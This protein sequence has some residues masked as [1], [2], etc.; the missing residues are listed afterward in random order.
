ML[1]I[2]CKIA[3]NT[4]SILQRRALE[5]RRLRVAWDNRLAGQDKAGTGVYAA[6]LLEQF[7]NKSDLHMDILKGWG[8]SRRGGLVTAGSR[9]AGNLFWTHAALP[10][11]LWRLGSQVL[12]SPAFV[13]P[14]P[15][16]CPVVTTIHDI[17]YLL[18]PSHFSKWWTAYLNLVMPSVV[19]SAAAIICPSENSKRDI[20]KAYGV[21]VD[22]IRV[23]PQ[24]VDHERFHPSARL[25]H[26]WAQ[27]LGI[28]NGYVLHIGTFSYRKNI[29]TLL[30]A[31]AELRAR[32]MWE[33]RQ[34]LLAGSQ[35]LSLKGGHEIIGTIRDLDLKDTVVL[36][37]YMPEEHVPGLYAH[38]SMLVMPSIYEGFGFP[39]L[40]AMATG[41]PVICSD[42]SSLPEVAGDAAVFFPPHDQHAL[43][44]AIETLLRTPSIREQLRRKGIERAS[45]FTWQRTAE[46]TIA[47]YR[48]VAKS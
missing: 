36:T 45:Q 8:P 18:Y 3:I 15:C 7:A 20:I 35:H 41:T 2:I 33:N 39:V 22:K 16:P 12:H 32:G 11:L 46:R 38:A 4:A 47:V 34:L 25:Q 13:T 17:S 42:E 9:A 30:R 29:P 43:A 14:I 6:R 28:R 37:G 5:M 31:V 24:G 21:R 19:K 48:E 10:A 40:E 27:M 1:K 26:A 23:V 44:N